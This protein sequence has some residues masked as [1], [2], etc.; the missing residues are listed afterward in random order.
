MWFC[1]SVKHTVP[2]PSVPLGAAMVAPHGHDSR[3]SVVAGPSACPLSPGLPARVWVPPSARTDRRV[4]PPH[5]QTIRVPRTLL[6][7]EERR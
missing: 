4:W 1:S 5:S 2:A 6:G 7:G 3:A